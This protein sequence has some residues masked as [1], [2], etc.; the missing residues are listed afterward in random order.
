M[1]VSAA[2]LLAAS[3]AFASV[4]SDV[5]EFTLSNGIRVITRQTTSANEGVAV[6]LEGGSRM[7][8]EETA[9]IENL[10]FEACLM[11]SARYPGET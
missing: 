6:F 2:I 10:A 7:L 9:G 11:G 8:D 4:P 3:T 5:E 1:S